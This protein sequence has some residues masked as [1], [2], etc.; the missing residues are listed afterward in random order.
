MSIILS[1]DFRRQAEVATNSNQTSKPLDT[2]NFI[3]TEKLLTRSMKNTLQSQ[4]SRTLTIAFRINKENGRKES[5]LKIA[6]C[7]IKLAPDHWKGYALASRC[8]HEIGATNAAIR[9]VKEG[10][11][12]CPKNRRL[13]KIAWKLYDKTKNKK[14]AF[15]FKL[16][17]ALRHPTKVNLQV[18]M[19]RDLI[20]SGKTKKASKLLA[21]ALSSTPNHQQLLDLEKN[22]HHFIQ[23]GQKTF[24]RLQTPPLICVAGNCQIQPIHE[25]VQ[26]SFPFSEIKCLPPYH[27]IEN[28]STINTWAQDAKNA[29]IIFMIPIQE[30]YN[31]FKIGSEQVSKECSQKSL[32]ISYP[33]F[34]FEAFYPLFGYAKTKA[35]T[36]LRGKSMQHTG[37]LYDDYH[38]FL[39]MWLSQHS[40]ADIENYFNAIYFTEKAQYQGSEVIHRA[41]VNSFL[42]FSKRYPSYVDI[43]ENNIEAGMGHTFN[44]PSNP[45]LREVYFKI[46]TQTLKLSPNH[47]I[48]YA[49]DPLNHL[50]LPIPSFVTR[51]LNSRQFKHPWKAADKIH[52]RTLLH[53]YILQLRNSIDIYRS[54]TNILADNT[55]HPKLALAENFMN[56]LMQSIS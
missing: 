38:D 14:K 22:I 24:N 25:W 27:L 34:H 47:F 39:A 20:Y 51:S 11:N 6:E 15:E 21:K 37:H 12:Y 18:Q 31:G 32:F 53:S 33:S 28:Q 56:E 40:D 7:M 5:A 10:L 9:T 29:D 2:S 30:G 54:N 4:T 42:E 8:L 50:Q 19:I 35:Q 49:K 26:E 55:S 45:F 3:K 16:K 43:L 36:T 52:A 44:H 13:L 46:W 1:Q 41:A 23:T 48:P 17:F